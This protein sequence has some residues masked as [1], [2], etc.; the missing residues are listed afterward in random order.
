[1]RSWSFYRYSSISE[2]FWPAP[3]SSI[4]FLSAHSGFKHFFRSLQFF[5]CQLIL[6]SSIFPGV[7]NSFFRGFYVGGDNFAHLVL[8]V[9]FGCKHFF[10]VFG[11]MHW[12]GLSSVFIF[13]KLIRFGGQ[14]ILQDTRPLHYWHY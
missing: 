11:F 8:L 10:G 4:L 12:R 1:M 14:E 7:F 5:F 2:F 3:E 9:H 6:G 13:S